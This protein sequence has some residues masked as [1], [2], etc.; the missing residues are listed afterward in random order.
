MAISPQDVT[1]LALD[2]YQFARDKLAQDIAD[3]E[4]DEQAD[5]LRDNV[6]RLHLAYLK[7]QNASFQAGNAAIESAYEAAT[8]A[9]NQVSQ[10]YSQGKALADRIR[11]VSGAVTAVASLVDKATAI[12]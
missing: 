7:A 3:A 10:A 12:A 5:A 1:D 8:A 11:A 4:N 9:T 2:N 6:S